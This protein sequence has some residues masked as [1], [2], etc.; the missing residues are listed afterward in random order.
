[1]NDVDQIAKMIE[2]ELTLNVFIADPVDTFLDSFEEA[3]DTPRSPLLKLWDAAT[4]HKEW[5]ACLASAVG[6][7]SPPGWE[8]TVMAMKK[9]PEISNPWALSWWMKGQGM[10]SHKQQSEG[11]P[12]SGRRPGGG[13]GV[14]KPGGLGFDATAA[15]QSRRMGYKK[16]EP[17][18]T[19][20]S[21]FDATA[22]AMSRRMGYKK[23]EPMPVPRRRT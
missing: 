2:R 21:G 5:K 22:A 18:P 19:R 3:N 4:R 13:S 7:V 20:P 8:G 12:G 15:A 23:D 1:M 11:G 9:H 6:E 17:M 10:D 14:K 16:D